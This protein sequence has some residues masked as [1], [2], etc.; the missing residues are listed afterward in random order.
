MDVHP[1]F[2][3]ATLVV[4]GLVALGTLLAVVAAIWG[5]S[6]RAKFV[7]P[8]LSLTGPTREGGV[9]T[10]Y[11]TGARAMF[12]QSGRA[13]HDGQGEHI[14]NLVRLPLLGAGPSHARACPACSARTQRVGG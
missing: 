14:R 5:D 13:S 2:E 1:C 9:P 7:P 12:I 6:L 10:T 3:V 4:H 8:K 11:E